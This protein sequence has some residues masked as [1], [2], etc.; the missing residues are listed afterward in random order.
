[1]SCTLVS[2]VQ[3]YRWSANLLPYTQKFLGGKKLTVFSLPGKVAI[4]VLAIWSSLHYNNYN[5]GVKLAAYE[6]DYLN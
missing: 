3:Q 1:M 6:I 2:F 5:I 4:H